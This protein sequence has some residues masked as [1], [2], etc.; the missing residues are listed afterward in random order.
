MKRIHTAYDEMGESVFSGMA[1]SVLASLP[2]FLCELTFFAKF[3]VFL[4]M[5]IGF[6]WLFANF[7]FMGLLA[8][9]NIP[10]RSK[11]N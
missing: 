3:G 4:C 7:F 8:Q 10:L 6:S 5:T 2:L 9:A 11:R 1:T